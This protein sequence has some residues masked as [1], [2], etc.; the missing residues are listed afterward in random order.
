MDA[1]AIDLTLPGTPDAVW[2]PLVD[3][4]PPFAWPACDRV[5]VVAPHPD[6]ETLGAGGLLATA[7]MAGLPTLVVSVTDGEAAGPDPLLAERRA[8]ELRAALDELAPGGGVEVLRL[9]LPDGGVASAE[10]ELELALTPIIT[11][12]DL[13]ICPL[14][15][16]GHPDHEACAR[17]AGRV[18]RRL[19][20]ALRA[21]PIWAWHW[22]D[23]D[24]SD[25][26]SGERL[27]LGPTARE[28]KQRAIQR[29]Q[30]QLEGA[31]P[32]VPAFMLS[33]LDRAV[34]VLVRPGWSR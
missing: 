22:H 28:R 9:G 2:S 14:A 4:L 16:D 23:P 27:L 25:I 5:V 10:P 6:D 30:S 17:A 31:D 18:C 12:G 20:A 24:D 13:V 15:D 34:E 8:S 33:R 11:S 26:A 1:V 3:S 29:Y 19:A 32:V 7:I 21:V